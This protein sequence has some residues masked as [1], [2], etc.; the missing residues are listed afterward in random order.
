MV[1]TDLSPI[2]PELVPV[3]LVF[4]IDDVELEWEMEGTQDFIHGRNMLG[5]IGN[6]Q[7][8]FEY[9]FEILRLGGVGNSGDGVQEVLSAKSGIEEHCGMD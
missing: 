4:H 7:L 2:Q 9:I 5:S 6:W 3:N 1:G 8:L